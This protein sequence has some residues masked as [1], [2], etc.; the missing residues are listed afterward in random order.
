MP[1]SENLKY[2]M[3]LYH[4]TTA[5][6]A[7]KSGIPDSTITK[8]RSKVTL[9]PNI[10]T[11]QAIAKA[12]NITVND[13][14]DHPTTDEEELRDLLPKNTKGVPEEFISEF[15]GT[16]RRQR[17]AADRTV[18]ELRRDRNFWRKFAV[19]TLAVVVPISIVTLVLTAVTYWDLCH[20]DQGY[21]TREMLET[22]SYRIT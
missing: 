21:I 11:L 1:V 16:L 8:I 7:E 20:P 5:Q 3:E 18:A 2:F 12:L 4:V 19:I 14:V 13:L 17:Q 6:L 9:N 22:L 15:L 10:D